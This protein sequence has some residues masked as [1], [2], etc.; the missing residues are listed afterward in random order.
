LQRVCTSSLNFE[1]YFLSFPGKIVF[2]VQ[3]QAY[4]LYIKLKENVKMTAKYLNYCGT[5]FCPLKPEIARFSMG[6]RL[7]TATEKLREGLGTSRHFHHIY[8][9]A[10][11]CTSLPTYKKRV[12][13]L[14]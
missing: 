9:L 12:R 10:L 14:F 1:I 3:F 4:Y 6:F 8:S 11:F 7:K 13:D 2:G 5:D